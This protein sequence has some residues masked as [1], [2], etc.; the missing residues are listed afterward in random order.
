MKIN[1]FLNFTEDHRISMNTVGQL[2]A[3]Y[4]QKYS[5]NC[6]VNRFLPT[7]GT[8]ER[9]VPSDIW[10]MRVAR[11]FTY[12]RVVKNLETVDISHIID[13]QYAHLV[14]KINSKVKIVTVHDLVPLIF[15][16]LLKKNPYLVKHSLSHLKFFDKVIAVSHNTKADILKH[17][18]CPKDKI[19]VMHFPV[20]EFFNTSIINNKQICEKF[21]IPVN[22]KKILVVGKSFYKNLDT[23]LKVFKNLIDRNVDLVL[24]KLGNFEDIK[25]EDRYKDKIFQITN[26]TRQEVSEIYKITDILL[27]PSIYEGYGLPTL[28]AMKSGVPVVCSNSSSLPEIVGDAALISSYADVNFFSDVIYKLLTDQQLYNQQK[29]EGIR[30]AEIFNISKYANDLINLY[31]NSLLNIR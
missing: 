23:S 30:R 15:T 25:I 20:E 14:H 16:K 11:Y 26:L 2:T 8:L 28:E 1:I 31:K 7:I 22:K 29:R 18:D 17:T 24:I 19:E 10:K 3:D 5:N 6:T 12:P 4:L 21:K 13:H 9:F 27:F